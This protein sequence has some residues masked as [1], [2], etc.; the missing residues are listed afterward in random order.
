MRVIKER[1]DEG[2]FDEVETEIASIIPNV[3]TIQVR[4]KH[5][6]GVVII[7]Q[8]V[9]QLKMSRSKNL[10]TLLNKETSID[11]YADDVKKTGE[12][13]GSYYIDMDG[14]ILLLLK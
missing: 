9:K 11:I 4:Q 12:V 6:G 1:V 14:W 13:R 2:Y 7:D 10:I 5:L 3:K 8:S